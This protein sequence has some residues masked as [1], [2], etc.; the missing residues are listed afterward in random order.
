MFIRLY[1]ASDDNDHKGVVITRDTFGNSNLFK[2][3]W[4]MSAD[5]IYTGEISALSSVGSVDI[6]VTEY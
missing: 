6:H 2:P 5:N 1:P 4:R 3:G